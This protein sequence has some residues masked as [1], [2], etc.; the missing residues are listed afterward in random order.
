M[1]AHADAQG[2]IDYMQNYGYHSAVSGDGYSY[3][4]QGQQVCQALQSGAS[5][6]SQIGRLGGLMSRAE[7]GLVVQGAHQYLCPGV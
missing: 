2:F 6:S 5:E 4:S 1:P 3:V 7:S